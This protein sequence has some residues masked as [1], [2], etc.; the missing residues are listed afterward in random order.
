MTKQRKYADWEIV[1]ITSDD[2][3]YAEITGREGAVIGF[4]D[5]GDG[6]IEYAVYFREEGICWSIPEPGLATTGKISSRAEVFGGLSPDSDPE[7]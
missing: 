2:P 7:Q 6:P 3:D 1:R 4:G 5:E